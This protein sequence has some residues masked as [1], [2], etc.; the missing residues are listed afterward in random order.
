MGGTNRG[1][2]AIYPV[3]L[4]NLLWN[5]TP[6][7]YTP[8]QFFLTNQLHASDAI[9]ADFAGLYNLYLSPACFALWISVHPVS[10]SQ[11]AAVAGDGGSA[12]V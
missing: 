3:V 2:C 11:P 12:S 10:A 7:S 8:M 9:Y 4:I 1:N 6:G 5:F